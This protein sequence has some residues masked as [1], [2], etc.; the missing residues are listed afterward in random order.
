MEY[1]KINLFNIQHEVIK[2]VVAES[3]NGLRLVISNYW[4]SEQK[5]FE[6]PQL[7]V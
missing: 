1:L 3:K 6:T 4:V 5:W 7:G 2:S